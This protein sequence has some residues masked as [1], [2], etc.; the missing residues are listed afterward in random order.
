M[1]GYSARGVTVNSNA[2]D[3]AAPFSAAVSASAG[4]SLLALTNNASSVKLLN[5]PSAS[6]PPIVRE[7][8]LVYC[9]GA[10]T[11]GFHHF[12]GRLRWMFFTSVG[13]KLQTSDTN[14]FLCLSTNATVYPALWIGPYD[15][16]ST[17]T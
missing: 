11:N 9:P 2:R 13:S 8:I 1:F 5:H 10:V 12:K 3:I 16:S 15:G 17:P 6:S 4:S 7:K 14:T